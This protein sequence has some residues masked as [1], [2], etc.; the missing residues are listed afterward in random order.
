MAWPSDSGTDD[1][2]RR[3]RRATRGDEGQGDERATSGDDGQPPNSPPCPTATA[4]WNHRFSKTISPILSAT[5]P[6]SYPVGRRTGSYTGGEETLA[7]ISPAFGR[8]PCTW[9]GRMGARATR[10]HHGASHDCEPRRGDPDN[11]P[12]REPRDTDPHQHLLSPERATQPTFPRRQMR[13]S[14]ATH[15]AAIPA[16][17][18]TGPW[19]TL[20][21]PKTDTN[22]IAVTAEPVSTGLQRDSCETKRTQF[23]RSLL[24]PRSCSR[25]RAPAPRLNDRKTKRTQSHR[26]PVRHRHGMPR[27]KTNSVSWRTH[28]TQRTRGQELPTLSAANGS[29]AQRE[30]TKQTQFP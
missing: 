5:Y 30:T 10:S 26:G 22:P 28:E 6:S 13:H 14:H 20:R 17:D 18:S 11:S 19:P 2:R 1:E 7:A 9:K 16:I 15:P 27:K 29:T 23:H 12:G 25:I 24:G 21:P 8:A 4:S 3:G